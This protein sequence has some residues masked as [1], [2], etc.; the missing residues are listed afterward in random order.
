MGNPKHMY[1][2][3]TM[4]AP[5]KDAILGQVF[6]DLSQAHRI[7]GLRV[8]ISAWLRTKQIETL[9]T[10]H[11]MGIVKVMKA[12]TPRHGNFPVRNAVG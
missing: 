8:P 10:I 5:S 1:M 9:V 4:H 11:G 6:T 12:M 3:P 7:T 2:P